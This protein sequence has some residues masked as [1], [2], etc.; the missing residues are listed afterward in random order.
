MFKEVPADK[1]AMTL[2]GLRGTFIAMKRLPAPGEIERFSAILEA[3]LHDQ[4]TLNENL[5]DIL[6]WSGLLDEYI[7]VSNANVHFRTAQ[8]KTCRVLVLHPPEF[9]WM[10]EGESSQWFVGTKLYRQGR[11]GDFTAALP[12]LKSD[13]ASLGPSP[14]NGNVPFPGQPPRSLTGTASITIRP[15][16][17][18]R[19][20]LRPSE[21]L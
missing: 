12:M 20:G 11:D 14:A 5:E 9:R 13:L 3:P 8:S 16:T 19:Q 6:A 2:K 1:F 15:N 7:C 17:K 18:Y 4:T 21:Y 10:M